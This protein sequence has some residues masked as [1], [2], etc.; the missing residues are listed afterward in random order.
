VPAVSPRFGRLWRL[1]GQGT[2]PLF[3]RWRDLEEFAIYAIK[4]H[5][6]KAKLLMISASSFVR[7]S[8]FGG[9]AAAF[10]I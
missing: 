2:K 7:H 10:L 3:P 5:E 1:K 6:L 8:S 9:R 4:L